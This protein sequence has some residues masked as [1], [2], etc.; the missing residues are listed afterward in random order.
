MPAAAPRQVLII[1]FTLRHLCTAELQH[2]H[3]SP[4]RRRRRFRL[5][6]RPHLA[7]RARLFVPS[8]HARSVFARWQR[9]GSGVWVST[10]DCRFASGR[11]LL[12]GR[13]DALER[14]RSP[15]LFA[16]VGV[17]E[18]STS[19]LAR[20][21]SPRSPLIYTSCPTIITIFFSIFV[22]IRP[23]RPVWQ[24]TSR[25]SLRLSADWRS[26]PSQ[27]CWIFLRCISPSCHCPRVIST[28]CVCTTAYIT[29]NCLPGN[30][31]LY[32]WSGTRELDID[33]NSLVGVGAQCSSELD[34]M[35]RQRAA[36]ARNASS[37]APSSASRDGPAG[38]GDSVSSPPQVR[39]ATAKIQLVPGL[40]HHKIARIACGSNF[41]VALTGTCAPCSFLR[42][43]QEARM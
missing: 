16:N 3:V 34:S 13:G 37:A 5:G 29:S 25:S 38:S 41:T 24:M 30:G 10:D 2:C 36:S 32:S 26:T 20:C 31:S 9:R 22:T 11:A 23:L 28:S 18:V 40:S 12:L 6:V 21:I 43:I 17:T 35:L 1:H 42:S 15:R 39:Y 27:V 8:S 33:R 4:R 14:R 7:G 19:P